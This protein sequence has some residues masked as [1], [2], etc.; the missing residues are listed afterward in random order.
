VLDVYT[1]INL[2]GNILQVHVQ[3]LP[4]RSEKSIGIAKAY[5]MGLLF[6][7]NLTSWFPA[8]LQAIKRIPFEIYVPERLAL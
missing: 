7:V 3:I 1:V 2:N 8:F 4:F 6:S 5:M